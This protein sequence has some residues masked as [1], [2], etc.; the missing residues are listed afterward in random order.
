MTARRLKLIAAAL[1][2]AT[3]CSFVVADLARKALVDRLSVPKQSLNL[4]IS[5]SN[6]ELKPRIADPL[7]DIHAAAAK[8]G[9]GTDDA[10][11]HLHLAD[12]LGQA[13]RGDEAGREYA[14][15]AD[16]YEPVVKAHPQDWNA[17]L[18][19]GKALSHAQRVG[20]SL[21]QFE[22]AANGDP[23]LWEAM[24]EFVD[25]MTPLILEARNGGKTEEAR[26]YIAAA[27][28]MAER[29]VKAA[30]DR[31]EP[32]ISRFMSHWWEQ[33]LTPGKGDGSGFSNYGT[34]AQ[35]LH[36]AADLAPQYPKLRLTAYF[37]ELVP[38]LAQCAD[39]DDFAGAIAKLPQAFRDRMPAIE[40]GLTKIATS[41][42]ISEPTW[43]LLG[44]M[45]YFKGDAAEAVGR[46]QK[47][48]DA[49]P[50]E[51]RA[52]ELQIGLAMSK[53][54]WPATDRLL[55]AL[56]KRNDN[57]RTRCWIGRVAAQKGDHAGAETAYRK[58]MEMPDALPDALLGLGISILKRG[59]DAN[60][61]ALK[62]RRAVEAAP[63]NADAHLGLATAL[64]LAGD[65]EEA[66]K[67]IDVAGKLAPDDARV[68]AT[69]GDLSK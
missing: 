46:L 69:K 54:D 50:K 11:T 52:L 39:T 6:R 63:D 35:D 24:V 56:V 25:G 65:R 68:K 62:L 15:A 64:A 3:M 16:M 12:A 44:I 27:Q 48:L 2:A 26:K 45:S 53:K 21:D 23:K 13:D 36:K 41:P 31:P 51:S 33:F 14:K 47:A 29:A 20:E 59:G 18:A 5:F 19:Y 8:I 7:A 58:A 55:E 10:E 32:H 43:L 66:R 57:G 40:A 30:P 1:F 42:D 4:Y 37:I 9:A 49:D 67:E 34:I 28:E 61:A 17:H 22:A 38:A 60:E